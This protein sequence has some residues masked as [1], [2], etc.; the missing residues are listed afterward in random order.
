VQGNEAIFKIKM[1][2]TK[3]EKLPEVNDEFAKLLALIYPR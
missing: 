1:I 3:Q 2:E